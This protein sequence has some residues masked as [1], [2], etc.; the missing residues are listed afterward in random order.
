MIKE[1]VDN[2]KAIIKRKIDNDKTMIEGKN[3]S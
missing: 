1:K 3:R 2:D